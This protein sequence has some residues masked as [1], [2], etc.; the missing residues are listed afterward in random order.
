[1]LVEDRKQQ[2]LNYSNTRFHRTV[3]LNPTSDILEILVRNKIMSKD[4][5]FSVTKKGSFVK[6]FLCSNAQVKKIKMRDYLIG[7]PAKNL[8]KI[9]LHYAV[10]RPN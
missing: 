3:L 5:I 4:A 7:A 9:P 2:E 8:L 10:V 6:C 1:M